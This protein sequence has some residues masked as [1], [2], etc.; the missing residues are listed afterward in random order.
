MELGQ[1]D[2]KN[3]HIHNTRTTFDKSVIILFQPLVRT[4]KNEVFTLH[5]IELKKIIL[6]SDQILV[7]MDVAD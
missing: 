4:S 1:V 5:Y 7:V 2:D 6:K 3:I